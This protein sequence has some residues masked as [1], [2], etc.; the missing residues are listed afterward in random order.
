MLCV[1][2]MGMVS[3]CVE[4]E[5]KYIRACVSLIPHVTNMVNIWPNLLAAVKFRHNFSIVFSKV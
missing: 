1:F 5:V 4:E 3:S 2:C